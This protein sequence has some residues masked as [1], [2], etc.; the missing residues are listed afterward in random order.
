MNQ[1]DTSKFLWIKEAAMRVPFLA[2]TL[3]FIVGVVL[4]RE[5]LN[6]V[7]APWMVFAY[8]AGVLGLLGLLLRQYLVFVLLGFC[9]L[10]LYRAEDTTLNKTLPSDRTYFISQLTTTPRVYGRY[11]RA[12][13]RVKFFK[14][15]LSGEWIDAKCAECFVNIDTAHT[16]HLGETIL[17]RSKLYDYQ[18][19][20]ASYYLNRG[21]QGRQYV[22]QLDALEVDTTAFW[23]ERF[24]AQLSQ[25]LHA[26]PSSDTAA[27]ATIEALSLGMRDNLDAHTRAAYRTGGVSHLLAISGLHVGIVF[28]VLNILL[29]GLRLLGSWGKWA[30]F[31]I[32]LTS[33]WA[34]ALLSGMSPSVV[35]A[36]VMFSLVQI[37][38]LFYGSRLLNTLLI[39]AFGM[40]MWNP[41][42]LYDVGFQLSYVAMLGIVVMF[43]PLMRYLSRRW[44]MSRV[45]RMLLGVVLVSLSAQIFT[46]PL[47]LYTF[48]EISLVGLLSNIAVWLTVPL[49]IFGG[50][51]YLLFPFAFLG[52]AV[53]W[54]AACQNDVI[55]YLGSFSYSTL[56]I[57]DFPLWALWLCYGIIGGVVLCFSKPPQSSSRE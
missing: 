46:A 29:W 44:R 18:E 34:Y 53:V 41:N 32:V 1:P 10:G 42:Y 25:R 45:I 2:V 8:G 7:E 36:V 26:I 21:I 47:V 5:C 54:V 17:Y 3:P 22:Y 55:A 38:L 27:V 37:G 20:Y 4:W 56:R 13:V 23:I 16:V 48:G 12:T 57:D 6:G 28:G 15:S 51:L 24:K 52:E 33:L 49:V 50:F 9:A 31:V 14:D 40:L 11:Q 19:P 39:A 43:I 35:R 30:S